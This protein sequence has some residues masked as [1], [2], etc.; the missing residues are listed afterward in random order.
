MT[1]GDSSL[2]ACI[3][4]VIASAVGYPAAALDYFVEAC[5]SG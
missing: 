1:T 2:S 4:S 3:Q 5:A